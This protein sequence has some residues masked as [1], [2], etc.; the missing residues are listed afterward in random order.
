[1]ANWWATDDALGFARQGLGYFALNRAATPFVRTVETGLVPG[2]Y[3][4]VLTDVSVEI[5]ASGRATLTI[6]AAG[7]LALE[8]EQA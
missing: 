2:R 3:R 6:P 4:D 8:K 1:M 5:G 7:A